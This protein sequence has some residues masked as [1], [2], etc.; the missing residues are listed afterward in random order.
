MSKIQSIL[1]NYLQA[2]NNLDVVNQ[3]EHTGR[4]PL[5]N[6]LNSL[7]A[8]F[9]L[10]NIAITHEGKRDKDGNGAPD[11]TINDNQ[12]STVIGYIE[13]KKI[14][15]NLSKILKSKQ[16]EKRAQKH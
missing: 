3:N 12:K 11:F 13:N 2:L 7:K 6:L 5:E 16:I 4:T 15:E 14:D 8:E 9:D 1:Q 10:G